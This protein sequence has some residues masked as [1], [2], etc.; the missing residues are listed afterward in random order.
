MDF[1]SLGAGAGAGLIT[2]ILSIIGFN[3]RLC[4]VE[5]DKATKDVVEGLHDRLKH[6][7][8]RLDRIY[9]KMVNGR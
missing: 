3:R 5:D 4:K 9:D 8:E 7:E 6:I 1:E 2:S